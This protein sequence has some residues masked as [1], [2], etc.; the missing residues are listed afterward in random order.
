MCHAIQEMFGSPK[1]HLYVVGLFNFT[2]ELTLAETQA[3]TNML[4]QWRHTTFLNLCIKELWLLKSRD[5]LVLNGS[6]DRIIP[7]D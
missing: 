4:E 1:T 6:V 7:L 3:L 2:D 5:D